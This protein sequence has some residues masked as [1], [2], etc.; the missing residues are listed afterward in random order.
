M[1]RNASAAGAAPQAEDRKKRP[2]GID[3]AEEK[4]QAG[5]NGGRE[6][7]LQDRQKGLA[8]KLPPQLQFELVIAFEFAEDFLGYAR[9]SR[10][11]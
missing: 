10:R 9:S 1:P 6:D 4:D 2:G 3:D 11:A 8:A 5:D 7:E